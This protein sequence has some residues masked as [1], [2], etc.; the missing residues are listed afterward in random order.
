MAIELNTPTFIDQ[1]T[2]EMEMRRARAR[3]MRFAI[4]LAYRKTRQTVY[5]LLAHVQQRR[6][7]A[8]LA[9]LDDRALRDIGLSRSDITRAVRGDVFPRSRSD[10]PLAA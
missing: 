2:L 6:A 4:R 1:S 7:A 5:K 3:W 9:K 8:E 10:R